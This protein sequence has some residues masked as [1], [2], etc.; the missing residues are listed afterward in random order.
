MGCAQNREFHNVSNLVRALGNVAPTGTEISEVER[1]V[2][3]AP[4]ASCNKFA[5]E[6][7]DTTDNYVTSMPTKVKISICCIR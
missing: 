6:D 7:R 5:A 2:P 4:D 1:P 3:P